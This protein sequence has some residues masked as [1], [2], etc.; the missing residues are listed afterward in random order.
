MWE[1]THQAVKMCPHRG[2]GVQEFWWKVVNDFSFIH[3]Y[4]ASLFTMR[5]LLLDK[6]TLESKV[7]C[8]RNR[9]HISAG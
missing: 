9:T 4:I 6:N 7:Q 5:L 3:I 8:F 1:D 2:P